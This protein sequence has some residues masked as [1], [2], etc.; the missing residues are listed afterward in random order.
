RL[1]DVPVSV[2]EPRDDDHARRVELA[3]VARLELRAHGRDARAVDQDVPAPEVAE[4]LVDR[5]HGG[6]ADHR[7]LAHASVARAPVTPSGSPRANIP[8]PLSSPFGLGRAAETLRRRSWTI[9]AR[10]RPV[11][12]GRADG[13]GRAV[14]R[15]GDAREPRAPNERTS[16]CRRVAAGPRAAG[17]ASRRRRRRDSRRSSDG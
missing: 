5:D 1:P 13:G 2:D 12:R 17:R 4:A 8:G 10:R 6:V 11:D 9:Y 15:R 14:A 3:R 16:P 7:A